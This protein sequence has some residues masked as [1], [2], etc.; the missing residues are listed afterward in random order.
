[1]AMEGNVP[2][3]I[4]LQVWRCVQKVVIVA[5]QFYNIDLLLAHDNYMC[6]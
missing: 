3:I 6:N 1:M 5:L 4:N 2:S